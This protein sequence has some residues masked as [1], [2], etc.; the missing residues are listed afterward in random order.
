M[1]EFKENLKKVEH[2]LKIAR[3]R[4][5]YTDCNNLYDFLGIDRTATPEEIKAGIGEKYKFYLTKQNA[6]DWEALTKAFTSTQPAV[7]YLLSECRPEYDNYLI[8][9]KVKELRKQF[10]SCTSADRELEAKAKKEIVEQG[11][12]VGL[13][14]TQII[15]IID[16]WLEEYGVK[17]ASSGDEIYYEI[18][19]IPND[20][21][22]AEIKK[23]YDREHEKYV[24]TKDEARWRQISEGWE[25][26]KDKD[27]RAAYDRKITE[28]EPDAPVLKVICMKDDYYI[29]KDVKKGASFT[30]TIV[31]KNDHKGRLLGRIISDAEWLVP[32]RGHLIDANEQTLEIHIVTSKLPVNTYEAKG[33]ITIE[34]NGG[35]P[36]LIPFRVI[37]ADLEIAADKF[38]KTY[39]PV[40]AACAGFIGS[41][42]NS[43]FSSFL[44]SAILAGAVS[45][46]LAKFIVKA[47]L[48]NGLKLFKFPSAFMQGTA[49]GVVV[50]TIL[51]HFSA[52]SAGNQKVE[53]AKAAITSP[54]VPLP[55]TEKTP[56][57]DDLTEH[58]PLSGLSDET[59]TKG[60]IA[61]SGSLTGVDAK[62]VGIGDFWRF[63]FEAAD[64]KAHYGF[65][66]S[67]YDE[68][69]FRVDGNDAD[70]A[71]GIEAMRARPNRVTLYFRSQD[72]DFVQ[73]CSKGSR[74]DGSAC[75]LAIVIEANTNAQNVLLTEALKSLSTDVEPGK[76]HAR[77]AAS[78][79]KKKKWKPKTSSFAPP[80]RDDL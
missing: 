16:R 21:D 55:E 41:F 54:P 20:A 18:F 61:L 44:I 37:L 71:A 33:T 31:I 13:S 51:S 78:I 10:I 70:R 40:A 23:I 53:Q 25:I 36:Y 30:E 14:E 74:C 29:Y 4:E 1:S 47:S 9:V 27:K 19:G 5:E 66:C 2:L 77:A 38:R 8:A 43:A 15:Q 69:F 28:P 39:V 26:L 62:T 68:L 50:L 42:S 49:G 46:A 17:P 79:A 57:L 56:V 72:W 11:I 22:Y 52:S 6:S 80:S 59:F 64:D 58:N 76:K 7:E 73:K 48:K 35:P 32:E 65:G 24:K 12:D 75:P 34:T 67:N 3:I 45:Y 63:G 60:T